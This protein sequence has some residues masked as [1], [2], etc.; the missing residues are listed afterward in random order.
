MKDLLRDIKNLTDDFRGAYKRKG[1]LRDDLLKVRVS[2]HRG[3]YNDFIID[4]TPNRSGIINNTIFYNSL[5]SDFDFVINRPNKGINYK[6]DKSFLLHIEPPS[7]VNKLGLSSINILNKFN[8]VY[9]SDPYLIEKN[10]ERYI[11][12]APYVHW[13]LGSNSHINKVKDE[14][15]IDYDFLLHADYPKKTDNFSV[16]NSNL[17]NI[18]GHKVRAEFLEK[19]CKTGYDFNLYGG[20]KWSEFKQYIDNAPNGK[21][22]PYSKSRYI[23][24][25]ENEKAPFYWSEK[26]AD[27][28]L[29]YAT[30]IYYGCSNMADFFPEGSYYPIDIQRPD[31]IEEIISI[32]ESDFHEKNI[33]NLIKARTLIFEKHN[34]FSFMN[35][36]IN[37]NL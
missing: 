1:L 25:I 4:Q 31:A 28:I 33:E 10:D 16:I 37:E 29:C 34:M 11:P 18:G 6:K 8:K 2:S 13:H 15:I 23:L 30:P 3:A 5:Y 17:M 9:T 12:S 19:F 32:V 24:V 20:H 27:A 7:Y 35:R 21:W 26:F 14:Y 36:V 22:F